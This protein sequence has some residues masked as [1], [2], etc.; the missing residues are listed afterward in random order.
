MTTQTPIDISELRRRPATLA[1]DVAVLREMLSEMRRLDEAMATDSAQDRDAV[2]AQMMEWDRK[3]AVAIGI[4]ARLEERGV[5][6][7]FERAV[8]QGL[9]P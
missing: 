6:R 7:A 9:L 4:A 5:F 2:D 3:A 1:D 8:R